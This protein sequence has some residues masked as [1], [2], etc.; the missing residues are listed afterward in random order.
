MK[1]ERIRT[2]QRTKA[3][4]TVYKISLDENYLQTKFSMNSRLTI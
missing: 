1:Q 3:Q 2:I 4:K